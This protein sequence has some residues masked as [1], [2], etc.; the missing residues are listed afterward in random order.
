MKPMR[1]RVP[2]G[3]PRKTVGFHQDECFDWIADLECGHQQ[4][5]RHNP[6]SEPPTTVPAKDRAILKP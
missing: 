4:H 5:V 2:G 3:I 1:A 6:L